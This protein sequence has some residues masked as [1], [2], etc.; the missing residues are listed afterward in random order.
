LS[1]VYT[2]QSLLIDLILDQVLGRWYDNA[3]RLQVAHS[4]SFRYNSL[5]FGDAI[6]RG[7]LN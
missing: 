3:L 7:G 4:L 1:V 2:C 6:E 5:L